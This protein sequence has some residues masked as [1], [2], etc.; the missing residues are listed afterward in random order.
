MTSKPTRYQR[1][2]AK[3]RTR[4][5]LRA[6]TCTWRSKP[7][8]QNPAA[9]RF[10]VLDPDGGRPFIDMP[11]C[12]VHTGEAINGHKQWDQRLIVVEDLYSTV[13]GDAWINSDAELEVW[14]IDCL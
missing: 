14:G 12:F 11:L 10:A 13:P 7:P 3:W 9:M 5:A 2:L 4:V 8:C 1:Y 6:C